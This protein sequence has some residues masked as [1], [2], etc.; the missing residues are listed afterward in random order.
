MQRR[1]LG[2]SAFDATILGAIVILI[3]AILL[4]TYL[5]NPARQGAM[6]A[7]LYPLENPVQNIWV[8]PIQNPE[9]ARAVTDSVMGIYDMD[10]SPDGRFIAYSEQDADTR[11]MDIYLIDLETGTRSRI[12]NCGQENDDCRTPTFHPEGRVLAYTRQTVDRSSAN[13]GIGIP[14]IWLLDLSTQPYTTRPISD[15]SQLIGHSPQWSDDGN[16][17]AFFSADVGNPGV[18][19]YNFNPQADDRAGL[20]FIPSQHGAVG[21][22]S[23]NGRQL[24]VPDIVDRAGVFVTYLKHVDLT[25]SPPE[26]RNFTDPNGEFDDISVQWNPDGRHVTIERRDTTASGTRGFQLYQVDTQTD[27][28]VPLLVDP[29]YSHHYF[30]WDPSG[31]YVVIQ[32]LQLLNAN[33]SS[34]SQARP[35][36]WVL[37]TEAGALTRIADQAYQPRWVIPQ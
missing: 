23:P 22:L 18:L 36:I 7:Y 19:V 6:V 13:L 30:E 31:R 8:A 11:L 4:A 9:Q 21:A 20:Y 3:G 5:G 15:D 17:L 29:L 2:L 32:R 28:I 33:G 12:T 34:A 24:I 37:D 14:R 16:T 26:I 10:V 1:F 35:E 25:V 27:T